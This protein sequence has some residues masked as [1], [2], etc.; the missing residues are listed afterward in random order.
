MSRKPIIGITPGIRVEISDDSSTFRRYA[1]ADD[2]TNAIRAAGGLPILL[3]DGETDLD[4]ILETVDGLLF[5]GGAD[6]DPSIYGDADVHDTT[7]G[8]DPRRDTYEIALIQKA[9]AQ[10]KPILG[11]CRGLQVINVAL[12]GTLIQDIPTANPE[13]LGH[14]QDKLGKPKGET[15][16]TVSLTPETPLA[17]VFASDTAEVNSFHHQA[18]REPAPSLEVAATAPDGTIEAAWDPTKHFLVAVQWHP[19]MLADH[20]DT[21]ASIFRAFVDAVRETTDSAE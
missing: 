14:S 6:I 4:T 8:V 19:E 7:Y 15:T 20:N 12:G 3:P 16:H 17:K 18:V 9:A 11:I 21:Q 5:S 10:D 13:S 2:Y 1:L